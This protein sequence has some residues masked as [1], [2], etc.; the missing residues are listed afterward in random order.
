MIG[1]AHT[2]RRSGSTATKSCVLGKDG[3]T[4]LRDPTNKRIT[5]CN[6]KLNFFASAVFCPLRVL[7][8]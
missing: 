5:A 6:G 3:M 2:Q 1:F 4:E 8:P 7:P